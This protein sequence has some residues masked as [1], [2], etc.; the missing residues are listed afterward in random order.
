MDDVRQL[1]LAGAVAPWKGA[2]GRRQRR[3][4]AV[5]ACGLAGNFAAAGMDVVVTDALDEETLAVYRASLE[6]VLVVRLEVAYECAR[7]RAMGRPIHLTWDE[8]ALLHKEQESVAGADLRL[9][10]TDLS[11]D[12]AAMSLLAMWA[13]TG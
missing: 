5:N 8:F 12:E 11:V 10:T 9:D 1:V 6:D 3:L 13:P 4:S 2:E 7:E